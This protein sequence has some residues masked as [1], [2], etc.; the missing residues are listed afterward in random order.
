MN[1][2]EERRRRE[3]EARALLGDLSALEDIQVPAPDAPMDAPS[4][5]PQTAGRYRADERRDEAVIADGPNARAM[6]EA[7]RRG[8]FPS[9]EPQL[10]P[11]ARPDSP[12]RVYPVGVMPRPNH[13]MA[14]RTNQ[15]LLDDPPEPRRDM[16]VMNFSPEESDAAARAADEERAA[17]R[18][19]RLMNF[20][21][22]DEIYGRASDSDPVLPARAAPP[23]LA[24][25][26]REHYQ[27]SAKPA[28]AQPPAGAPQ[29]D[30]TGADTSD[31]IR[32]PLHNLANAFRALG[33]RQGT[34]FRSDRA[35][36]ERR[37]AQE[38]A[39]RQSTIDRKGATARAANEVAQDN[40]EMS[41]RERMLAATE[42]RDRR[43]AELRASQGDALERY[44]ARTNEIRALEAQGRLSANE[45][46]AQQRAAAA[47]LIRDQ[48]DPASAI[49]QRAQDRYADEVQYREQ[50]TGRD[51]PDVDTTG[52][53]AVDIQAMERNAQSTRLTG[54]PGGAGRGGG[55]PAREPTAPPAAWAGT[56]EEWNRLSPRQQT[57]AI[58]RL[59]TRQDRGAGGEGGTEILPGVRSPIALER[60]EVVQIRN[61]IGEAGSQAANLRGLGSIHQRYGGLR[62]RISREAAAEINPRLTTARGMVAQLGNTGVINPG[63]VPTINAALPNPADLE[64]MSFGTFN[65]RMQTWQRMLDDN[66]RARLAARGVDDAGIQRVLRTIHSGSWSQAQAQERQE[67]A[68]SQ[69]DGAVQRAQP[70]A[71]GGEP[72]W[73][74]SPG[75]RRGRVAPQNVQTA[76]ERGFRRVDGPG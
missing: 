59:G 40:R 42:A 23:E 35:E 8:E 64:Q 28:P 68:Q 55:A 41:L 76:I 71:S 32:R 48:N 46:L 3:E 12:M 34:A 16:P 2:E 66:I 49:S 74:E 33:G 20:S 53:S 75:G 1:E 37:F 45:S 62:A 4:L 31:A 22:D 25:R 60:S 29:P 56:P 70:A 72:V 18:P 73:M 54:R 47:Q 44:R 15:E 17:A 67:R 52:R 14:Q 26:I 30:Y 27:G 58:S 65:T 19:T 50:A 61:G 57:A 51:L 69:S 63:E 6:G 9:A 36:A 24:Q 13:A 5:R 39:R 38:E 10:A 11:G 21:P 7:Y 43:N